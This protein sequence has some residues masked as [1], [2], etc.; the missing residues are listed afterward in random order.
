M[1]FLSSVATTALLCVSSTSF[2]EELDI[3]IESICEDRACTFK[4]PIVEGRA[5]SWYITSQTAGN[6]GIKIISPDGELMAKTTVYSKDLN[7]KSSGDFIAPTT[8][9]YTVIF[10]DMVEVVSDTATIT[11]DWGDTVSQTFQFAGEDWTDNDYN[12]IFAAIT[13]FTKKG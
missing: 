12:D 10:S 3:G 8:E 9:R 5:V 11:S 4:V 2:A 13:W 7:N 1:K 6:P